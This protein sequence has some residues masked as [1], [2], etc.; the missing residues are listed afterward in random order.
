MSDRGE[1]WEADPHCRALVIHNSGAELFDAVQ[2]AK[3]LN[4]QARRIAI[5]E[6]RYEG[7]LERHLEFRFAPPR[8]PWWRNWFRA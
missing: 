6:A 8:S 1:G 5:L 7:L 4:A 3:C 2:V